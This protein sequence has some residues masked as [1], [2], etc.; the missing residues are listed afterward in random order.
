MGINES[1]VGIMATYRGQGTDSF[2]IGAA[3]PT[4]LWTLVRGDTAAFRVYVTDENRNPLTISEWTISM[5]VVRPSTSAL[6]VSLYPEAT[7]DDDDGEFTVSLSS[8]QSEDLETGDIFDIQLSDVT[9]TWTICKGT[10]TVIEDVTA[11][12]S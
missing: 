1:R 8:G 4:V 9:R 6:V 2:S 10:I 5:D 3:P 11:A 7:L 12:E